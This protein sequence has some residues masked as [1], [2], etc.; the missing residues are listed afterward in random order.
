MNV[1][2]RVVTILLH[3]LIKQ[4]QHIY[5]MRNV[6]TYSIGLAM[7]F[8]TFFSANVA[9]AKDGEKVP[10]NGISFKENK[11]QLKDQHANLRDDIDFSVNLGN[12]GVYIGD[13]QIHYQWTKV[14]AN[15]EDTEFDPDP[16]AI[17][18]K[19]QEKLSAPIATQRL[20]V[21]LI[22]ANKD[23]TIVT[24]DQNS[25]YD[26]YPLGTDGDLINSYSYNTITYKDIYPNIDWV[27]YAKNGQ[28]KYDFVVHPGGNVL[29]IK[30]KYKGADKIETS[31]GNVTI[32]TAMGSITEQAPY[33]YNADTKE[34][35]ASSFEVSGNVLRFGVAEYDGTLVIDPWLE[36]AT[37]YGGTGQEW[38]N[39]SETDLMGNIYMGGW[40]WST[41]NIVTSG[42]Y[43]DTLTPHTYTTGYQYNGFI[44]KFNVAGV[45]QWATYFPGQ[46]SDIACANNGDIYFCGSIDSIVGLATTGAHQD[47]FGGR[48]TYY[49][50]YYN[51]GDAYLAKFSS[52]GQRIWF[53]YYGG[54]ENDMGTSVAIDNNGDVYLGGTTSSTYNIAT[55]GSFQDTLQLGSYYP[56][57]YY[58]GNGGF[59]AKFNSNGVRQW[60]TYFNGSISDITTD[61][62]NS[63]YCTG[64]T[65]HD[66]GVATA[67]AH[68]TFHS[69]SISSTYNY[70]ESFI[71]KFSSTGSR[72]WGSYYGGFQYDWGMAVECDPSGNVYLAGNTQSTQFMSTT[73]AHQTSLQG[74]YDAYLAKFSPAGVRIWGT[75]F[76]GNNYEHGGSLVVTPS[77]KIFLTGSTY[78]T[79]GIATPNSHQ[80]SHAGSYDDYLVEFDTAGVQK[81]GT[82]Y[83]GPSQEYGWGYGG[84]GWGNGGDA[85]SY[86]YTGR[87]HLASSTYSSTGISTAGSHQATPGNSHDAYLA[88]FIIDTIAYFVHPFPD[89]AFCVG[90]TVRIPYETSYRFNNGNTFTIE[91]SDA[92]GAFGSPVTIGS[93]VDT[94]ADTITCVIP[95]NTPTGNG[96]RM[97]I[98][99]TNPTRTSVDNFI[100][101]SVYNPGVITASNNSPLCAGDTLKLTSSINNT[102]NVTYNWAGPNSFTSS[103][104]NPV[105]LNAAIADA[106]DYIVTA[107]VGGCS[108][109]DTTTVIVNPIPA[110]PQAGSNTPVCPN[111]T[112]SLFATHSSSSVAYSWTGPNSFVSATQNPSISN[113]TYAM[114]GDYIV[115]VTENGCTSEADTA[116]VAVTITTPTPQANSNS[117]V[118]AGQQLILTATSINNATYSWTGPNSFTSTQQNPSIPN[119]S[120]TIAGTYYV[121]AT[122][123]GCESLMDSVVVTVNPSATVAIFPSPGDSICVGE[124]ATFVA[125][126]NNGGGNPTYTWIK[127]GTPISGAS[128][129]S[130][131]ASNLN[132]GD[133]I[134]CLLSNIPNCPGHT[135][136]SNKVTMTVRPITAP[137]VSIT[138]NPTTPLE[139]MELVTFTATSTYGGN[140]PTFQWMRNGN[141]VVGATN[142]IWGT[143]Q[144]SDG[145]SIYVIITSSDRCADPD[146]AVSN[147]I[148][149]AVLVSVDDIGTLGNVTLFPNPNS[150]T[151]TI[152][153][154]L[155]SSKEVTINVMNA[156]GQTVYRGTA[157]PNGTEL[158]HTVN[159]GTELATGTY[160]LHLQ[161]EDAAK[162]L[163]FTISK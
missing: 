77:Y 101:L 3:K 60:G 66:S 22:G 140:N 7:L 80:T 16:M 39:C 52:T 49:N 114:A 153:G 68:Q 28:L 79:T 154:Q 116:T 18:K 144:M 100:D 84:Y 47:T 21:E 38:S 155:S 127:N 138:A 56:G 131:N 117:P 65:W 10:S 74:S 51:Q 81:Y 104:Q 31:E 45:R 62:N 41:N 32:H 90:D 124:T 64:N 50:T 43:Q 20:D 163:R 121:K 136:T 30:I 42:A 26:R 67:G 25:Y 159:I 73:G 92:S 15:E 160:I 108:S 29:D 151:F 85:L 110:K 137:T 63:I 125:I 13:A 161:N 113:A 103:T 120:S 123:N 17:M 94:T 75:Y 96:Y 4:K 59:L 126:T 83:G 91:L 122:V 106:G 71:V 134:A 72:T 34:Q 12:F 44:V 24:G 48:G 145:D 27:L 152:K 98:V 97:R 105:K 53:T 36:W 128:G 69:A 57:G 61:L 157:K 133:I 35:I 115:T 5:N 82:Y 58:W 19:Q 95:M 162:T 143:Y 141:P 102:S 99:S 89:T 6:F 150:G 40:T 119:A 2:T 70:W 111:T 55:Q 8:C 33:S 146:T 142:N 130:Y 132:S 1:S 149:V 118:C 135:D 11:G 109:T 148:K 88:T 129:T 23:A 87:I 14:L 112:L 76:G 93:R 147:G 54:T 156:I 37:Y 139:P 107:S 9:S 46:V 86:N 78:S 158:K